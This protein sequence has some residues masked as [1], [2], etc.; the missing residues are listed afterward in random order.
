MISQLIRQLG[1][2]VGGVIEGSREVLIEDLETNMFHVPSALGSPYIPAQEE[3]VIPYNIQSVVG[4]G[5]VLPSGQ[6]FAAICFSKVP[7]ERETAVLFSHLSQSAKLA[8]LAYEE[9]DS[10]VESQI[11]SVGRLL[12]NYEGVVCAQETK[13]A[14]TMDELRHA[15]DAAEAAN[16]SKSEFLANMS[17]EI[18]TPMNAVIGMTE[19]VL[20]MK[21]TATQRDYLATVLESAES[22]LSII[23]EI[24][25]FS[26][27]EAGKVELERVPFSLREELGDTMKS[28]ALRAHTKGLELA[29][30]AERNVPDTLF[31]DPSRLRQVLVN[32]TGNAVKFTEH[33]EVVLNVRIQSRSD[34]RVEL[35]F[36]VKDT[37]VG[38]PQEKLAAVFGA[39]EQAD[40]STTR[41]FGGTGLGLAIASTLVELMQG[42][43][44]VES[45]IGEGSTFLFTAHFDIAPADAVAT[46]SADPE[47]VEGMHALIVDDN[48]TNRRIL[49]AMLQSWNMQVTSVASGDEALAVLQELLHSEQ[50]VA[51]VLTDYHMPNM[52][53]FMLA[54]RIRRIHELADTT[55]LM[56]TSGGPLGDASRCGELGVDAQLLKPVK[57]SELLNAIT[58]AVK[59]GT[60]GAAVEQPQVEEGMQSLKSLNVLLA[61]DGIANQKLAVGLLENWGHNVA[62]ANDG[63][64]A[65]DLWNQ[66]PFDLILMDVQMPVIDG[67]DAT[68]IIRRSEQSTG[69]HIPIVALTAH[70]LKGDREKCLS[71]GMDDYISK[72]VRRHEL[73][74]AIKDFF[75]LGSSAEPSAVTDPIGLPEIAWDAALEA[76]EGHVDVLRGVARAAIEELP[77]L[78]AGLGNALGEQNSELVG[79]LAHTIKGTALLFGGTGVGQLA[80]EIE[81][82]GKSGAMESVPSKLP[83]LKMEID[84]FCEALAK[85]V[86]SDEDEN[87]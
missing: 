32:L 72:P 67:L 81:Q 53:G 26:K 62:V 84:Q 69:G 36:A 12:E 30:Y 63:Q 75:P 79:R 70:A 55:I 38:I 83:Q 4:F 51:L 52:D 68:R 74:R 2:S 10:Q 86:E 66:Q 54:E 56:L 73:Y 25:D 5:D 17:H 46:Q 9:G 34:D 87:A 65:V 85:F 64:E 21:L 77:Q 18:R 15:R 44:W 76:V 14:E 29:W 47:S 49:E 82:L 41:R 42:R 80:F 60:A 20:D 43:I 8:M 59:G 22:L 7:V 58:R 23:N 35:L 13:L 24:L 78:V 33:G 6:L 28:L 71:A 40:T 3:F 11:V 45:K 50:P 27:I 31:G 48:A 57:Q 39:F 37:G 19:L 1:L 16:R 61:E